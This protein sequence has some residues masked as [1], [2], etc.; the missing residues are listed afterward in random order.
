M[1]YDV[2]LQTIAWINGRRNDG[3]LEI[4]PNFQRRP[5]WMENERSGLIETI[6][7][8]LPFPE[9]YIH[10]D[11]NPD[12]GTQRHIIVDGQ[13]RVTSILMFI[14]GDINLPNRAPWDGK[15][16][17]ELS[18]DE[19]GRF[20]DYK[21]VV[22]GLSQTNDAEIRDLF[23][24]LNTNNVALNDQELRNAHY[25]GR[26]KQLAE[27]MADNPLFQALG[28]FTARDIRRMLDVE[29]A[30]ELLVLTMTG[31]TN[32]K[33]MLDEAYANYEEEL[34]REAEYEEEFNI[35]IA[36]LRSLISDENKAQVKKKSN[37]YTLYG[38]CLRYSRQEHRTSFR[39]PDEVSRQLTELLNVTQDDIGADRP[40]YVV[41]YFDAVTRAASD[42]GRRAERENIVFDLIR[43]ADAGGSLAEEGARDALAVPEQRLPAANF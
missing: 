28:L 37:F 5:V 42:K 17:R 8:S 32:K 22:R 34:P 33:D 16:F 27:R 11:T 20:W 15:G 35:A 31:V 14:D 36:L 10:H 6:C 3:T 25:T 23:A 4:S 26:F 7:S 12:D 1:K 2:T 21:V 39:R 38:A 29:Y 43:V 13:Q 30:S 19:K 9:I 18:P 41:R 24:R 40:A